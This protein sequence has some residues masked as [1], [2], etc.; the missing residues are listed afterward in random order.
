MK[1]E[2]AKIP[3]HILIGELERRF[4]EYEI[5]IGIIKFSKDIEKIGCG[6][7][8]AHTNPYLS[9]QRTAIL[10]CWNTCPRLPL[11]KLEQIKKNQEKFN[12]GL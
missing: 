10:S 12:Q 4:I 5:K 8:L 3:S 1:I 6:D 11:C 2:F 9:P 7:Y